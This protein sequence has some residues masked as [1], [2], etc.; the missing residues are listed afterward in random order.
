MDINNRTSI[1]VAA[2]VTNTMSVKKDVVNRLKTYVSKPSV[3][4]G[5]K[6]VS[7]QEALEMEE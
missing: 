3:G 4:D 6:R 1:R 2:E 5:V 7:L